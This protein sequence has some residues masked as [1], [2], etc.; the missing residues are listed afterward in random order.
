[1]LLGEEVV[2]DQKPS[3]RP[4]LEKP[5]EKSLKTEAAGSQP[6]IPILK[7]WSLEDQEF[8]AILIYKEK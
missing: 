3:L 8:K 2:P 5:D 6:K 4:G 1:M 7:R